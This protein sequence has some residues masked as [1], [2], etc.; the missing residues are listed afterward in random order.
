MGV[1]AHQV[2]FADRLILQRQQQ[3][4][5]GIL[6]DFFQ[7]LAAQLGDGVDA[8]ERDFG[9]IDGLQPGREMRRVG[10]CGE[11]NPFI[12]ALGFLVAEGDGRRQR[13]AEEVL[14]DL[15]SDQRLP[16]GAAQEGNQFLD[17]AFLGDVGQQREVAAAVP[18]QILG[19][20][21][22]AVVV[23]GEDALRQQAAALPGK[24]REALG[25]EVEKA[26][27]HVLILL[28]TS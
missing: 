7:Q 6:A 21:P 27:A 11:Q 10:Q 9:G 13:G 15:A 28:M 22:K 16:V 23:A 12:L 5:A 14:A 1:T 24:S 8:G 18:R 26:A 3:A 19:K 2:A 17:M 4:A 20:L 25:I